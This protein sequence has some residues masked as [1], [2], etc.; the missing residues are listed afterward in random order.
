MANINIRVDDDLKLRTE[1]IFDELGLNMTT[2]VTAFLKQV[3]RSGGIP[4]EMRIDPWRAYVEQAL[5]EADEEAKHPGPRISHEEL[6][7]EMRSYV[8]ELSAQADAAI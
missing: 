2:A 5:D 7:K 3:V 6:V 1:R 8:R 4:F